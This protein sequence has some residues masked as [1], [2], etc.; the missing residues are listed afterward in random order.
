MV[1]MVWV[2]SALEPSFLLHR[3][4]GR[5][6]VIFSSSST[7]VGP[8]LRSVAMAGGSGQGGKASG[9]QN[10][11]WDSREWASSVPLGPGP[12]W[13]GHG[14]VDQGYRVSRSVGEG[15]RWFGLPVSPT[16]Q[17]PPRR[18]QYHAGEL[19]TGRHW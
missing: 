3:P 10:L 6:A 4:A 1:A 13:H 14:G 19:R 2:L 7:V 16:Q 9:P 5:A 11:S 12:V 18:S 15:S 17:T 8:S